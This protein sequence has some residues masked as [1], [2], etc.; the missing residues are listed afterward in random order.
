MIPIKD[1]SEIKIIPNSLVV[2]EIDDTIINFPELGK[3]WWKN[4]FDNYFKIY[5]DIDKADNET[6]EEWINHVRVM[7]PEMINKESFETFIKNVFENQCELVLVTA[8][9][10]KI[11]DLTE[12]HLKHCEF[13]IDSSNIYYSTNKG[14]EINN[15]LEK[16]FTNIK[17]II[18]VDDMIKNLT[19]ALKKIDQTK[20]NLYM[21]N[22]IH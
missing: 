8:R 22:F 2:L 4:T 17:N 20:Y 1:Y 12:S 18:F 11:K 6:L 7:K 10:V 16:R 9:Q 21:Y 14:D 13:I 3:E 5:N 19:D 15:I